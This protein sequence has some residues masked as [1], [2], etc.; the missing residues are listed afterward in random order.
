MVK[1]ASEEFSDL[2]RSEIRLAMAEM[3]AKGRRASR[4]GALFGAAAVLAFV[5]FEALVAAG[6]VAL[7]RELG[8]W[9]AALIA[10]GALLLAAA[11]CAAAARRQARKAA[12]MRPEEAISGVQTDLA[13]I[14]ERAVHHDKHAQRAGETARAGVDRA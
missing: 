8:Y 9:A 3:A 2:V 11:L 4:G 14:R 1:Q 5:A 6:I 7:G 13:T 10:G 12:P